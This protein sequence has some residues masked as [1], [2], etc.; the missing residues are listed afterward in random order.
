[1]LQRA[2]HDSADGFISLRHWMSI[3]TLKGQWKQ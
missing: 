2:K 1:V 3:K